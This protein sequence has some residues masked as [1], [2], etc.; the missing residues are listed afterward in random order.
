MSFKSLGP[1]HRKDFPQPAWSDQ[2]SNIDLS[3]GPMSA[4]E[5][6]ND[7]MVPTKYALN[8]PSP[9]H[10]HAQHFCLLNNR[11]HEFRACKSKRFLHISR[12]FASNLFGLAS[13][14]SSK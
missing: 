11:N 14:L 12:S 8:K 7:A 1:T 5:A 3:V 2:K 13:L 4:I 6:K 10:N 9:A